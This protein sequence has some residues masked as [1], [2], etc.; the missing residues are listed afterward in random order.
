[1]TC[2]NRQAHAVGMRGP[3]RGLKAFV[4]KTSPGKLTKGKF[5]GYRAIDVNGCYCGPMLKGITKLLHQN[6]FSDGTLDDAAISS[7][8][9]TPGTWK[10]TNGGLRRGK[11]VDSQVSRL[12][13]AGSSTREKSSKFK[14]TTLTFSALE[15][16]GLEP[17][18]GQRVV[19]SRKNG[20]AT[21][22]D[23][24]CLHAASKSLVVVELK[25][26]FSGNRTLPAVY[27]GRLQKMK[28]P[29]GGADDCVLNRH[30]AQLAVTRHL[31]ATE[32]RLCSQL[33]KQFGITEIRGVLLYVCD[34]DT[35]IHFLR[36]WWEKRGAALVEKLS[37]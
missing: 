3:Q 17:L 20:I 12:A 32:P 34:R 13:G 8:E 21:A 31:F 10:G 6:L 11:A 28:A 4:Q 33:K 5:R 36:N 16:A 26:G 9:W 14:F 24:I 30:F 23:M 15:K 37:Q 18:L 22:A 7:T 19:L 1:M 27:K 2:E 35:Q 29:C 25:C